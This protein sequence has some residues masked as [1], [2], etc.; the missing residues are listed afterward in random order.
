MRILCLFEIQMKLPFLGFNLN[1]WNSFFIRPQL[2]NDIIDLFTDVYFD[3]PNIEQMD[4]MAS[5]GTE[6]YSYVN[7]YN[8][9]DIFGNNLLN[10]SS[11]AHGTDII[12]LLG[13][14]MYKNFF[15]K[16]FQS[17][18]ETRQDIKFKKILDKVVIL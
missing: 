9:V 7:D 17:F 11:A 1:G 2:Y 18:S 6:I 5:V 8:S 15:S 12:Y 14:T 10:R 16:D 4:L 13:P 3:S